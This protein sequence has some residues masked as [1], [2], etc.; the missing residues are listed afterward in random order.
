MPAKKGY[1]DM[2]PDRLKQIEDLYHAVLNRPEKDRESWL[3]NACN[4]D[5]TL[6]AEVK[7]LLRTTDSGSSLTLS[8]GKPF[9]DSG[10]VYV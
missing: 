2:S 4:G 3:E 6:G 5:T 8:S 1:L 10:V 7:S 9:S